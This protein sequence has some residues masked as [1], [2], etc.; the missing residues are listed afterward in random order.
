MRRFG[1]RVAVRTMVNV[2]VDIARLVRPLVV[3]AI[4]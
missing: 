4:D 2:F 1:L 3:A